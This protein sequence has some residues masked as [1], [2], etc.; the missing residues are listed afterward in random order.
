M[1]KT[2]S[3]SSLLLS[4]AF[5]SGC[6]PAEKAPEQQKENLGQKNPASQ[7]CI[8]L[9]GTLEIKTEQNGQVGYCTLQNGEVIEEWALF[10][11]DH[12]VD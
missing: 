12:P 10:K 7:Y 3:I 6:S 4:L 9:G 1:L 2:L 11:R 5:L 8:S